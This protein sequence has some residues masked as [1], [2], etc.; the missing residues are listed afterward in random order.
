MWEQSHRRQRE[1]HAAR[2]QQRER[3]L[4]LLGEVRG[5]LAAQKAALDDQAENVRSR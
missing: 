2:R 4:E 3:F 5:R 1:A